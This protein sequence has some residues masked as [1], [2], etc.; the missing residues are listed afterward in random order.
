[1]VGFDDDDDD[2]VYLEFCNL[3]KFKEYYSGNTVTPAR[4]LMYPGWGGV[5]SIAVIQR[6]IP[7]TVDPI[8]VIPKPLFSIR[9][10]DSVTHG[11]AVTHLFYSKPPFI[12]KT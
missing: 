9:F 8:T 3:I 2:D 1:L 5:I 12:R 7:E 6:L 10:P 11:N 4:V